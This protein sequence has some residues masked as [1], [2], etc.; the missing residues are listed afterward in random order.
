[1]NQAT[2]DG[3]NSDLS[4]TW[5]TIGWVTMLLLLAGAFGQAFWYGP[6]LPALVVSHFD[7]QGNANGAMPR[8]SFLIT[9]VSTQLGIAAIFLLLSWLIKILPSSLINIPNRDYW[10]QGDKRAR[11]I[12]ALRTMITWIGALSLL[13][14]IAIFQLILIA[15]L[16]QQ[17]FNKLALPALLGI[18]LALI[19]YSL[20]W[21]YKRFGRLPED[22]MTNANSPNNAK[23]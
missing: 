2:V 4:S 6:K 8:N 5:F 18:F 20:Y 13:F 14:L 7:L 10:L 22:L 17:P 1:M 15:N 11:T 19:A 3:H 12:L 9:M 23:D 21:T 16:R